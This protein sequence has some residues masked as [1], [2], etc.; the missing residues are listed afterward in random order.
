M[1]TAADIKMS[2]WWLFSL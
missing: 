2:V 1:E